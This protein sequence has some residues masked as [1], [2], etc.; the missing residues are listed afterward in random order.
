MS[1]RRSGWRH[2]IGAVMIMAASTLT[3]AATTKGEIPVAAAAGKAQST[4]DHSK[5]KELEGPF[6]SGPEVT[7]ACLSCH[8]EASHQ[9]MKSIHWTWEATSPTTGQKLGKHHVAN[10]FCGSI[11]SNEPRCT[12]CHAGYGWD[13]KNFDFSKQENVDCLACH[14]TTTDYKK[15]ATDAGHPLYEPREMPK[16]SGKIVQPPD[17]AK[18]AQNVGKEQ[19]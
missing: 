17:L 2:W 11:V 18:I 3:M 19:L 16:G 4:A 15:V 13:D 7:K 8:T 10:N 1:T 12:S 9:V 14:D 6:K 5:F